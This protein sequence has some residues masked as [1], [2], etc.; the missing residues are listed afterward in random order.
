MPQTLLSDNWGQF[1]SKFFQACHI[2]LEIKQVFTTSYHPQCNGQ[3]E[4]FI[5]TIPSQLR[6][7]VGEHQ[8]DWDLYHG[9]LAFAYNK[10]IHTSTGVTPFLVVLSRPAP[11]IAIQSFDAETK[12]RNSSLLDR[13]VQDDE[14][15]S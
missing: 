4:R 3:V 13:G 9:K 2:E 8:N 12:T 11:H 14:N 10:Q 5:M 7:Y 6:A 15:F 1:N